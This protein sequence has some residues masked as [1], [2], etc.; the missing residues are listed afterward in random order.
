MNYGWTNFTETI[1]IHR[2]DDSIASILWPRL[3]FLILTNF[4]ILEIKNWNSTDNRKW[5]FFHY[6]IF[7]VWI[8]LYDEV[9]ANNNYSFAWFCSFAQF[10]TFK[11]TLHTFFMNK[12]GTS[13]SEKNF[14]NR[15]FCSKCV[16]CTGKI[17]II[18]TIIPR[19][20]T[21]LPS[22]PFALECIEN[23]TSKKIQVN[24]MVPR[25]LGLK[26]RTSI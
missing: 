16:Y 23:S 3:I 18:R 17:G 20:I 9:F 5:F 2:I 13:S 21:I 8:N 4:T 14:S 6:F 7:F 24:F 19:P 22:C 1:T 25:I 11:I 26:K 10:H 12:C 15:L